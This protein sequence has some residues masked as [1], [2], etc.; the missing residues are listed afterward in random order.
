MIDNKSRNYAILCEMLYFNLEKSHNRSSLTS[1]IALLLVILRRCEIGSGSSAETREALSSGANSLLKVLK[2]FG[3]FQ[4]MYS[5][6][7]S[8]AAK[9]MGDILK[10][11]KY[12]N[13]RHFEISF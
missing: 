11:K 4:Q 3:Y 6:N 8:S 7:I 12:N 2:I 5:S 1:A 13:D 9:V 10:Q